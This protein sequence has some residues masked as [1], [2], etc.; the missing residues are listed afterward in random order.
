MLKKQQGRDRHKPFSKSRHCLF[1]RKSKQTAQTPRNEDRF[2]FSHPDY[3]CVRNKTHV[4]IHT[5]D[6]IPLRNGTVIKENKEFQLN[7]NQS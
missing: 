3:T 2:P 4:R 5:T 6:G 1:Q 7:P